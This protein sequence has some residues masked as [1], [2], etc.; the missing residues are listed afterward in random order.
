MILF[1]RRGRSYEIAI[2]RFCGFPRSSVETEELTLAWAIETYHSSRPI[3]Y[4]P[5]C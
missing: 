5:T 1:V 3:R 4:D 2:L